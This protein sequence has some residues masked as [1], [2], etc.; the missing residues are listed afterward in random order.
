MDVSSRLPRLSSGDGAEFVLILRLEDIRWLTGFTGGTAQ[1]LVRRSTHEAWLLVDGRYFER[2]TDEIGSSHASVHI[3][4]V[5]PEV[6]TDEMIAQ[7][8]SDSSVAVDPTHVTAHFMTVLQSHCAVIHERTQLDDL[9]RVK[10]DAE[11]SLI[12]SAAGIAD[13]ALSFVVADG[14]AGKTEKQIR[15]RLDHLMREAGADDVAFDTIVATGPLGAR[16]HHEPSDAIVEDGHGVVIDF[17]AMVQGYKSDMT[18]TI[19]VGAVSAEYQRMF[20]LVI[21]A[22]AAGIASVRAGVVGAAVDAAARAVF[23]REGVDHEYVHGT[24]HGIGLYI[25]EQP[26]LSPRCTAVLAVNEV[27]TVEPGLY[28]GGVGGVRIEDLVVVTGDS[29]RI[30]THTPK[31]LTCPRSPRT[32]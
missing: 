14:L 21:E 22:E 27:V 5:V 28:R 16:P 24:G 9:R 4:R 17:G 29:C 2:A 26:I 8:V 6:S 19:R 1:L 30:L 7:I 3:E 12:A 18:R 10:D 25:H 23:L 31:D 11:I 13:N 32:I 15:N 20:D